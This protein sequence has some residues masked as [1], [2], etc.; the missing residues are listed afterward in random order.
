MFVKFL[1]LLGATFLLTTCGDYVTDLPGGYTFVSESP[2]DQFILASTESSL[3][4]GNIPVN[5][6]GF[7]YDDDFI[8][9]RQ[10]ATA[11][12]D[13]SMWD[14]LSGRK[15]NEKLGGIYYWIIDAKK[16]KIS[17]PF[18]EEEFESERTR[19]NVSKDLCICAYR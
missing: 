12:S 4:S 16:L 15:Y 18:S 8:V 10:V 7:D 6:T 11:V 13:S 9:V 14:D 2:D 19:L 5:V 17:G 3:D 1:C